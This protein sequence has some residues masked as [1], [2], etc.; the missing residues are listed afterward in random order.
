MSPSLNSIRN[1]GSMQKN[2]RYRVLFAKMPAVV[3]G[4]DVNALNLLTE[5]S[6]IPR[7]NNQPIEIS[8]HGHR[9]KEPGISTSA[10]TLSITFRETE[11]PIVRDFIS[12]W[13]EGVYDLQSGVSADK[14]GVEAIILI[15]Q[16]DSNDN[17]TMTYRLEGC[18]LEEADL[19]SLE[20]GSSETQVVTATISYDNYTSSVGG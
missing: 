12:Q 18:F 2:Y 7:R 8:L 13:E 16:L 17:P 15:Q 6:E 10:G 14:A 5:S 19:G 11:T 3:S 9:I 4:I 20:G 1:L